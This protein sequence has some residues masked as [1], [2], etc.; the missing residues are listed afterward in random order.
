MFSFSDQLAFV[1][2]RTK[3]EVIAVFEAKKGIEIGGIKLVI[4]P[5]KE[6]DPHGSERKKQTNHPIVLQTP[7]MAIQSVNPAGIMPFAKENFLSLGRPGI[8]PTP[9]SGF[10]PNAEARPT[11]FIQ[12][13]ELKPAQTVPSKIG[14][15]IESAVNKIQNNN[16]TLQAGAI[17]TQTQLPEKTAQEVRDE[18]Y[19]LHIILFA[20]FYIILCN[21]KF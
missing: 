10:I 2:Y 12:K 13:P 7:V 11:G 1:R 16:P 21:S 9:G 6:K 17:A 8:L 3:R 20:V 19:I 15:E 5:A 14:Q 4:A 18:V